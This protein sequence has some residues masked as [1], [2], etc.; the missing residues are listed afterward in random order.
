MEFRD[1]GNQQFRNFDAPKMPYYKIQKVRN[2]KIPYFPN[3]DF[4]EIPKF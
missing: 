3:Y 1:S 2:P 4:F